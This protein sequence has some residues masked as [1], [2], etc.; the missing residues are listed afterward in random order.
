MKRTPFA[1][2]FQQKVVMNRWYLRVFGGLFGLF[3]LT[4]LFIASIGIYAVMA[5][6]TVNRTREIGVHLALGASPGHIVRLVMAR[7]MKQLLL[8]LLIG[9]A[10]AYPA[11]RVMASLPLGVSASDPALFLT[12][13]V[14][15]IGV[16]LFACYLPARRAAALDPARAIRYE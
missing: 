14:L 5:Q 16:G 4:G 13:S 6:A 2:V 3:A 10:A 12:V 7:G 8:G 11:A 1:A 9:L 15:L